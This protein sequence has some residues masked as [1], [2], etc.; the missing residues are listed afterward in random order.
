[1]WTLYGIKV[2]VKDKD[3]I[4]HIW[5]ARPYTIWK[6]DG[7]H[8]TYIKTKVCVLV[9]DMDDLKK[10]YRHILSTCKALSTI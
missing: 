9:K 2:Y 7:L 1:M 4:G 10:S 6:D 8:E 5:I 3:I